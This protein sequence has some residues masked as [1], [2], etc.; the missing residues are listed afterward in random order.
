MLPR[1]ALEQDEVIVAM[2][3]QHP[4]VE[5]AIWSID[6]VRALGVDGCARVV[7]LSIVVFNIHPIGLLTAP[8]DGALRTIRH[9]R[10]A[11]RRERGPVSECR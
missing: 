9:S 6:R 7:A 10:S 1:L 2:H 3:L 4:A 11:Q 5:S 8:P